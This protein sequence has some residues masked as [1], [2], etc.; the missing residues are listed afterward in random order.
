MISWLRLKGRVEEAKSY[1]IICDKASN[2]SNKEQLPFCLRYVKDDG[3]VCEDFVKFI[4]CKS[5]LTGKRF[6]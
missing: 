6:M 2:T 1:S 5:G 4:H 3:D